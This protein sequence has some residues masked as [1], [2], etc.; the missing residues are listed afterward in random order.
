MNRMAVF[1]SVRRETGVSIMTSNERLAFRQP[2]WNFSGGDA[3]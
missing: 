3:R 2:H 1:L